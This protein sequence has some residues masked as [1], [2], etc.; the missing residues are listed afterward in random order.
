MTSHAQHG[1]FSVRLTI[2]IQVV[3]SRGDVQPFLALGNALK[4]HGHR[5]RLAT[6]QRRPRKGLVMQSLGLWLKPPGN[7]S[8]N[9]SPASLK[10]H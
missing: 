6:Q 3:D 8:E 9:S 7:I 5:V 2:V 10:A 1:Y 4:K